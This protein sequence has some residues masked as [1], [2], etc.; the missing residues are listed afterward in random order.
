MRWSELVYQWARHSVERYGRAEVESWYWEVWNE[1][2]IGYWQGTPEEYQ[3]LYD[4]A[5]DG[6]KRAL[7]AAKIG[8]PHVTGP[9][10]ARPQQFLRDFLEHCLRGK[11]HA[12]TAYTN[13][14][15][16]SPTGI[17]HH[18]KLIVAPHGER[19][20]VV[21]P[22]TGNGTLSSLTEKAFTALSGIRSRI[23][24]A[25]LDNDGRKDVLVTNDLGVSRALNIG[26]HIP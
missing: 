10:G 3:K 4:F 9:L 18:S 8:G 1:P 13:T 19:R 7:P 5:A 22:G 6:L 12:S 25:D 14:Y 16:I 17:I 20:G 23:A 24:I 21:V 15:T 2:D 11:N 26:S